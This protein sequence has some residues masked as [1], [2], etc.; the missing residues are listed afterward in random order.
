[1][2]LFKT[3]KKF[4]IFVAEFYN[5][6]VAI[7]VICHLTLDHNIEG[8]RMCWD[9]ELKILQTFKPDASN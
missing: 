7:V 2:N 4:Q 5:W 9:I 3:L 8:L 1:M 6:I